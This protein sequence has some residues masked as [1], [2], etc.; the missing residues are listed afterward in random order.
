M[1]LYPEGDARAE[2]PENGEG[3]QQPTAVVSSN[4]AQE[5]APTAWPRIG[6]RTTS[7]PA[8]SGFS[9]PILSQLPSALGDHM[10]GVTKKTTLTKLAT[11]GGTSRKRALS[12]P[13][14]IVHQAPLTASTSSAGI[15]QR[16]RQPIGMPKNDQHQRHDDEAVP[17][18]EQVPINQSVH[19][20]RVRHGNGLDDP[21]RAGEHAA[22]LG[23]HRGEEIPRH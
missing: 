12:M 2:P 10:I 16:N 11:I 3:A 13:K 20:H 23:D 14:N 22:T 9:V 17:E 19:M 6:A 21:L 4:T 1:G 7:I 15:A 18:D 5:C 8:K